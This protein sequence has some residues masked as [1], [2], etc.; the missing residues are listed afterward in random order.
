MKTIE[1]EGSKYPISFKMKS[2][3]L[4]MELYGLKYLKEYEQKAQ[5]IVPEDNGEMSL[6][7]LYI[8]ANLVLTGIQAES[9]EELNFGADEILDE[10]ISKPDKI[11]E[12]VSIFLSSQEKL[13]GATPVNKK[14]SK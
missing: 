6:D 8:F 1:I 3:R 7:S 10:I 5:Q 11:S 12:I 13:T 2:R 4:F 14:K 9:K